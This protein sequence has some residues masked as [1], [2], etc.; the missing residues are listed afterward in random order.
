[1]WNTLGHHIFSRSG[2]HVYCIDE[3]EHGKGLLDMMADPGM[4]GLT[5]QACIY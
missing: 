2:Q 5:D 4:S 3:D 1:M